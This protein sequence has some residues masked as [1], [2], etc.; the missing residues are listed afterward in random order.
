MKNKLKYNVVSMLLKLFKIIN[1]KAAQFLATPLR[2]LIFGF[3][4]DEGT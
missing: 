3:K 2:E 1:C 4:I